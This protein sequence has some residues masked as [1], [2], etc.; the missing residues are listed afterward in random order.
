M[1][2]KLIKLNFA[3]GIKAKD[4]NHNFDTIKAWINKERR[5]VG[6]PGIVDGFDITY[7]VGAFTVT[8]GPGTIVSDAGEEI[9]IESK[10]F[11]VGAPEYITR[12]EKFACPI[13]GIVKVSEPP[14]SPKKKG[15]IAYSAEIHPISAM[16]TQDEFDIYCESEASRVYYT[17]IDENRVY[18]SRATVWYNKE[19]TFS[20]F[21]ADDRVDAIVLYPDGT[22]KYQK[23]ISSNSPSH[24]ELKDYPD[25]CMLVGVIHWIIGETIKVDVYT[26]HRT[27]RNVYVDNK[28]QLYLNGRLYKPSQVIYFEEPKNP[29]ENDLWYD[30]KNNTLLVWRESYGDHGWVPINDS[31]HI[32]IKERKIWTPQNWPAD[33]KTF[34]FEEGETNLR[35]VPNTNALEIVIDNN[36]LMSDQYDEAVSSEFSNAPSYL[37]RGEGFILKDP[38]DRP[39]YIEVTVSHQVKSK[40]VRETFQRA[41]IFVDENYSIR[42]QTNTDQV[43]RTE[44]QYA[45]GANQLEVWVDGVRLVPDIQFVEMLDDRNPANKIKDKNKMSYYYK[46]M[47]PVKVGATVSYRINK[48]MWS[49]DQIAHMIGNV[50]N[51]IKELKERCKILEKDLSNTNAHVAHQLNI[52]ASAID[53]IKTGKI[54]LDKIN[55][56]ISSKLIGE[57]ISISVS[58]TSLAPL[59]GVTLAKSFITVHLISNNENRV[60]RKD[61]D[62]N[63]VD[64]P[65]GL[66]V[67]LNPEFIL[68]SNTI[69]IAGIKVG[70]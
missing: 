38:L 37:A 61:I 54:G 55:E 46:V 47:I 51:D 64:T 52:L 19:L 69:Y 68:S 59:Q 56:D 12:R 42:Q 40:P 26:N 49:Y 27:Y 66:R 35:F 10:T 34:L 16:P 11:S 3:P 65:N 31:S 48:H 9:E 30:S 22:Y 24:V 8:V 29:K 58:A 7:D 41:A 5:R 63:L 32:T 2:E 21:S 25:D 18:I 13:D 23:S 50:H 60:L 6:G 14:Y 39:T 57:Q 43:F 15:R 53:E 4:I 44:Y 20:Y 33:G 17:Q 62:Y 70:V 1:N 36:I 67:D 45:I 28:R